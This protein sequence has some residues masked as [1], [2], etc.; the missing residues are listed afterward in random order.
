MSID[1]V[2]PE[3]SPAIGDKFE[4]EAEEPRGMREKGGRK[5]LE[6]NVNITATISGGIESNPSADMASTRIG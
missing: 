2:Y 1:G 4:P 5:D 3:R 6:D